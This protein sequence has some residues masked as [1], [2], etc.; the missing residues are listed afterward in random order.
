VGG[1]LLYSGD[2]RCMVRCDRARAEKGVA[3][4]DSL[5]GAVELHDRAVETIFGATPVSQCSE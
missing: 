1:L 2:E 4:R 5:G 3:S